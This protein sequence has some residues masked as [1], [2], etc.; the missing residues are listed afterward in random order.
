EIKSA[1]ALVYPAIRP[2]YL[3]DERDHPVVI[4]GIKVARRIAAAPSMA[5]HIISEFVP[6]MQFQTDTQ[7][8]DAA[9]RYSQTIYHP[10]ST[11]KMGI[12]DMAVVDPRLKVHG[13]D[14]LRVVDCSI[15]PEIVSGNTHAP[16]VM[17]AEKAADM[18]LEDRSKR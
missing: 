9:R 17:I 10:A 15:M 6:G 1:D 4:G 8:L 16:A 3:S 12:D 13:I 5:P 2:N 11:C 18:I 14:G 7:L